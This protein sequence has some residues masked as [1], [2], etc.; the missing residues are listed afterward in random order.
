MM[1][2]EQVNVRHGYEP[3]LQFLGRLHSKKIDARIQLVRKFT[4]RGMKS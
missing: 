4:K 1:L 2:L 3:H